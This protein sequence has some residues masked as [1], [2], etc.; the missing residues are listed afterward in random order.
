VGSI[1][2]MSVSVERVEDWAGQD[3]F[4]TQGERVGKLDEVYY[5]TA[6]GDAV[7]AA[8]KS[9]LLGR[10]SSVVPLAGATVG[11]DYLRLAYTK[12]AIE[13]ADSGLK[14][15]EGIDGP[16]ARQLG[17]VYG[18]PIAA[19]DVFESA[20]A[21]SERRQAAEEAQ[22]RAAALEEEARRRESDAHEA[23]GSAASAQEQAA[24]KAR[25]SEQA[26]AEAEQARQDAERIPPA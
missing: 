9:G 16:R 23:E 20:T 8:V 26:R 3:V 17:E 4:D 11:R 19:D 21:M 25:D 13:D 14:G 15:D 1:T 10:R 12:L 5:S 22:K 7:F 2:Y 24:A 18:V 6:G